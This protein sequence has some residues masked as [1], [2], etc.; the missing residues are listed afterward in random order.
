MHFTVGQIARYLSIEEPT[1]MEAAACYY[2]CSVMEVRKRSADEIEEAAERMADINSIPAIFQER[3]WHKD[4]K[5]NTEGEGK[6]YGML[7]DWGKIKAGEYFD[8]KEYQK[9][10]YPNA[11][12]ILSILYRPVVERYGHSYRIEPYTST[13]GHEIFST[14]PAQYLN[15]VMLFFCKVKRNCARTSASY[16]TRKA[17]PTSSV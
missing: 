15:G 3:I 17:N 7:N 4:G 14:L 11:T 12:R 6:E 8:V 1:D 10:F 2:N 16:L 9:E 5:W 13:D